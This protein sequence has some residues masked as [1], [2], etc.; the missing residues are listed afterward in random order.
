MTF[1]GLAT[2]KVGCR[3]GCQPAFCLKGVIQSYAIEF[4]GLP[5]A[6]TDRCSPRQPTF[7]VARP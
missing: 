1:K 2:Q 3:G 5:A 6:R 7:C 4:K